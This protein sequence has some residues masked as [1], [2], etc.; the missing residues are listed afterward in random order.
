LARGE[1][2]ACF[3][4]FKHCNDQCWPN[5][6]VPVGRLGWRKRLH[7][8]GVTFLFGCTAGKHVRGNSDD[9]QYWAEWS[10]FNCYG[11]YN[12][13]ILGLAEDWAKKSSLGNRAPALRPHNCAQKEAPELARARLLRLAEF[14]HFRLRRRSFRLRTA[15]TTTTAAHSLRSVLLNGF[16]SSGRRADILP[17]D[18]KCNLNSLQSSREGA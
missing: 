2:D 3:R 11:H 1:F 6:N 9:G 12:R 16:S 17:V 15:A 13:E 5:G 14:I 8:Y 10:A 18:A 7:R 4:G